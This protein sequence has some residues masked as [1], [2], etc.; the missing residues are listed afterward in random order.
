MKLWE[1][2]GPN[3]VGIMVKTVGCPRLIGDFKVSVNVA[4]KPGTTEAE[5][6]IPTNEVG[7]VLDWAVGA[8]VAVEPVNDVAG[9]MVVL[10]HVGVG[11]VNTNP[12]TMD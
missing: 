3:T 5:E 11:R 12:I 6:E 9:E 4:V 7:T 1:G 2:H 10:P 8:S